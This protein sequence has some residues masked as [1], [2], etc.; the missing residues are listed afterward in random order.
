[1]RNRGK[2]SKVLVLACLAAALA[3]GSAF[4]GRNLKE[5]RSTTTVGASDHG[6]VTV[7]CRGD[8]K[9]VSGGFETEFDTIAEQPNLQ[10]NESRRTG[11][12]KWTV[13]AVNV[14]PGAS[15][16]LTSFAYCRGQRLKKRSKTTTVAQEEIGSVTA[17]CP[18]GTKAVSGGFEGDDGSYFELRSS[19]RA[20]G[21]RWEVS[22]YNYGQQGELKATVYCGGTS[23]KTAA[24]SGT[25]SYANWPD[26]VYTDLEARCA[27]RRTSV[28]GGFRTDG[29]AVVRDSAKLGN[30]WRLAATA[31]PVVPFETVDVTVFAYCEKK[32]RNR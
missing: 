32:K 14:A 13:G 15:G 2:V 9:V 3:S 16:D 20:G 18:K 1:V 8:S 6:S 10:I 19:R 30:G 28:S 7:K 27:R 17:K 24:A 25:V 11:R 31:S 22:G 23:L 4:A 5:T 12:R 21:R 26:D 29:F